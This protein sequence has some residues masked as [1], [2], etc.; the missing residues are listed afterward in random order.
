MLIL[1]SGFNQFS[2]IV[3]LIVMIEKMNVFLNCGTYASVIRANWKWSYLRYFKE[4][5]LT[6]TLA[7]I[8]PNNRGIEAKKLCMS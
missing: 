3:R 5:N 8:N 6:I 2:R 4:R 1:G 7:N